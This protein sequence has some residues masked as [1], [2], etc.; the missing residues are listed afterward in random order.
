MYEGLFGLKMT[1]G[2]QRMGISVLPL[3]GN[4]ILEKVRGIDGPKN[5]TRSPRGCLLRQ[6]R[7]VI[8]Q[9]KK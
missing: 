3:D 4:T 2:T 8:K 1:Y 5:S 9:R 6:R 7:Q